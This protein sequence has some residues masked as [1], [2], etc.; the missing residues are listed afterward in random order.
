MDTVIPPHQKFFICLN[1]SLFT[2]QGKSFYRAEIPP[3]LETENARH[4][5][6]Q[7]QAGSE[8]NL[9]WVSHTLL[10][11]RGKQVAEGGK[12]CVPLTFSHLPFPEVAVGVVLLAPNDRIWWREPYVTCKARSYKFR[13]LLCSPG[14]P[15]QASLCRATR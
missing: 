2:D 11:L 8:K 6:W 12:G 13:G 14:T 15:A 4:S 7:P 1:M 3:T 10:G 5:L 9:P